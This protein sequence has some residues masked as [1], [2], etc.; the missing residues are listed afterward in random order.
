MYE[1]PAY[2]RRFLKEELVR[3]R[4]DKKG[5]PIVQWGT[6]EKGG[7]GKQKTG[8][9]V[10]DIKASETLEEYEVETVLRWANK[11]K[12]KVEVKWVGY[13]SSENTTEPV[14]QIKHTQPYLDFI[15]K[16]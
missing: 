15:K 2:P 10:L 5:V 12:T 8:E 1:K 11:S 4:Q 16:K 7:K 14:T 13:P 6:T 3:V 9:D